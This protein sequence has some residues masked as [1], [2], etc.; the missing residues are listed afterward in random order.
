[1]DLLTKYIC[2]NKDFVNFFVIKE[3]DKATIEVRVTDI[4]EIE[5]LYHN[6]VDDLYY[7]LRTVKLLD[8]LNV[9]YEDVEI[10]KD[11]MIR[12]KDNNIIFKIVVK[13]F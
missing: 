4:K 5:Y 7:F 13:I 6:F 8:R 10:S 3:I 9:R 2:E 1:M 12:D 11:L